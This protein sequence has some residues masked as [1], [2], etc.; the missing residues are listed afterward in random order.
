MHDAVNTWD[1]R[2]LDLGPKRVSGLLLMGHTGQNVLG[3]KERCR[4]VI[5]SLPRKRWTDDEC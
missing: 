5:L 3:Y 1:I 2:L 4:R